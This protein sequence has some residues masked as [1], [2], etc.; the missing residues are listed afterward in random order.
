MPQ[1]ASDY[2]DSLDSNRDGS[3][4]IEELQNALLKAR[5]PTRLA[6]VSETFKKMDTD[7]DGNVTAVEFEHYFTARE[8]AL[9]TAFDLI[10][11]GGD[12]FTAPL[13]RRAA[14]ASGLKLSDDDIRKIMTHMDK[15]KDHKVTFTEFIDSLLLAPAVNPKAFFDQWFVDSFCDDAQ[16]E[17]TIPREIR[18]REEVSFSEMVAKKLIC[19]G[20]AGCLSRTLTAPIDRVRML[21]MTSKNPMGIVQAATAAVTHPKGVRALWVG[22]G[23]NCVKI[24]PEMAIKLVTFDVLRKAIAADS[25]NVTTFERFVAG[26]TAGA[27]SQISIYPMEVIRTR[28]ATS[29]PGTYSSALN[30]LSQVYGASGYRALYAGLAPS[31]AGIIP[32]A[33]IDLSLNSILKERSAEYLSKQGREVSVPMLLGCGMCSSA[34]ATVV[35]FPLNVIRTQAQASGAAVSTV[36]SNMKKEGLRGFYRGLVPCLAKVLPATSISY[37]T[38][39]YLGKHW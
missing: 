36:L 21:M 5:L 18:P 33:A 29:P 27:V 22:N 20:I 11:K 38:Y 3:I 39:E 7:G 14:E 2:F 1:V 10:C 9:K 35:T 8:A 12:H 16:S 28:L 24:T 26:G 32:Y 23:V 13:L 17:F 6:D 37:A 30:C 15:N 4:S 34:V 19:G 31:I 25:D